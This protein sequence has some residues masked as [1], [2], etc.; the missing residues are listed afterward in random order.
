MVRV[1]MLCWRGGGAVLAFLLLIHGLHVDGQDTSTDRLPNN[2]QLVIIPVQPQSLL[3]ILLKI[4]PVFNPCPAQY[5]GNTSSE[6]MHINPI[7]GTGK[8]SSL[9]LVLPLSSSPQPQLKLFLPL[10]NLT[11][12]T[13]SFR[14]HVR[15]QSAFLFTSSF[16]SNEKG[17]VI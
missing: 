1:A 5:N 17:N 8:L 7:L 3:C 16:C 10:L 4:V 12:K 6:K 14:Q 13:F 15:S 2:H 9:S 11:S